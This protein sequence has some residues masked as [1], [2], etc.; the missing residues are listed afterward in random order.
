M[1]RDARFGARLSSQPAEP[2]WQ[3]LDRW[4]IYIDG[5]RHARLRRRFAG[6]FSPRRVETFRDVVT[7]RAQ[8]RVA[9]VRAGGDMDLVVEFV[10]PLPFSVIVEILGVPEDHWDWIEE[11]MVVV[12]QGF[13]RQLEQDFVARA[14]AAAVDVLDYYSELL[15]DR[16]AH[17]RDDLLS[18]LAADMPENEDGRRESTSG[19]LLLLLSKRGT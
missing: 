17:P 9:R 6:L 5:E 14:S 19:Q 18:A 15:D 2:L 1:L 7:Q 10:G 11:Q 16:R 8:S 3:M 4:L 13:A 12:G